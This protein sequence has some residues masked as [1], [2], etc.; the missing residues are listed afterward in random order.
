MPFQSKTEIDAF[1]QANMKTRVHLALMLTAEQNTHRVG[2]FP[3]CFKAIL[4]NCEHENTHPPWLVSDRFWS[5]LK[6]A[7]MKTR[8]Y[9]ALMQTAERI[10]IGFEAG[11]LK[12]EHLKTLFSYEIIWFMQR[13]YDQKLPNDIPKKVFIMVFKKPNQNRFFM[14]NRFI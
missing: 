9:V 12:W 7:N 10:P 6:Q 14:E 13:R 3:I 1:K 11:C 5:Y 2:W 4:S 8:V